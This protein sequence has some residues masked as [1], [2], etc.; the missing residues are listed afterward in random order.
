ME[1]AVLVDNRSG[2]TFDAE[3]CIPWDAPR[4]VVDTTS[5][6]AFTPVLL[7]HRV[8]LLGRDGDVDDRRILPVGDGRVV[9]FR[10]PEGRSVNRKSCDVTIVVM[11]EAEELPTSE[12]TED[13]SP[14]IPTLGAALQSPGYTVPVETTL[15]ASWVPD[16]TP[17]FP[18]PALRK[19]SQPRLTAWPLLCPRQSMI[20][21]PV[22]GAGLA[23]DNKDAAVV[24]ATE[25]SPSL[26]AR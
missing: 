11:K 3:L 12:V 22:V 19:G 17:A 20:A 21:P 14:G 23:G 25:G 8:V 13:T 16:C 15:G 26:I 5:T 2:V 7:P 6:E 9:R 10:R 24:E 4:A 18:A 1:G